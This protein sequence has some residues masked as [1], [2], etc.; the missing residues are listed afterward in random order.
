MEL[1]TQTVLLLCL[2]HWFT[3][4]SSKL[5]NDVF[6]HVLLSDLKMSQINK[7]ML[8]KGIYLVSHAEHSLYIVNTWSL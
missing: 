4:Q 5:S 8:A 6:F 2:V 3:Y 1:P 7:R